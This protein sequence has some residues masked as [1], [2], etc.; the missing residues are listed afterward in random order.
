MPEMKTV[1]DALAEKGLRDKVKIM[2]G[3]APV[4]QKYADSIGADAYARDA[5][6]AV[7]VA[8]ELAGVQL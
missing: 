6:Q 3:G 1:M 2:V 7:P 4:N 8:K 5:G